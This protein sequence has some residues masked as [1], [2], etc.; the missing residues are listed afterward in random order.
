MTENEMPAYL[1]WP[2]HSQGGSLTGLA[3]TESEVP[4]WKLAFSLREAVYKC[5][6]GLTLDEWREWVSGMND[7]YVSNI[8]LF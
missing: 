2:P 5:P 8:F 7:L 1:S 3:P 4:M 6:H